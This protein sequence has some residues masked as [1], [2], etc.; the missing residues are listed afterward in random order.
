MAFF[1]PALIGAVTAGTAGVSIGM[2]A[3][4]MNE[5]RK[6]TKEAVQHQDEAELRQARVEYATALTDLAPAVKSG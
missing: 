2:S 6:Q 1:I 5:G 4:G 3:H